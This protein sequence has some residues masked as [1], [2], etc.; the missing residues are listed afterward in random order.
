MI[1]MKRRRA[2]SRV[3]ERPFDSTERLSRCGKRRV[4]ALHRC[5]TSLLP[6]ANK[7]YP[8]KEEGRNKAEKE[9][10]VADHY[11]IFVVSACVRSVA[12]HNSALSILSRAYRFP[13]GMC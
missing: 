7:P 11:Q 13:R 5:Q 3:G 8:N 2:S 4:S 9:L 12:E 6:K 10:A 1:G